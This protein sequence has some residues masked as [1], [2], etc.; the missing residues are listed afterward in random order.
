MQDGVLV[1]WRTTQA[2]ELFFYLLSQPSGQTKE[3]IGAAIWPEHSSAKL[4]SIFRS[5]LFRLRKALFPEI[6]LFENERYR[7]NPEVEC[8]YDVTAFEREFSRAM[9]AD[10][11]VQKAY[12]YRRALD[13]YLGEY[14]SDLYSTW[15]LPQ[16]EALRVRQLQ[17]LLFLAELQLERG[18][19]AQAIELAR[20]ILSVDEYHEAAHYVLVRSYVA[21]G[22]RPQAKRIYERCR[23]MLATFDLRLQKSWEELCQ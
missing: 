18:Q 21:S 5:S 2:K 23:Q 16:R 12:R 19:Y 8:R 3:Q 15:L 6:V 22:Q 13:L 14:L 4:F 10:N 1:S 9:L 11:P 7:L 20:Q 17:A